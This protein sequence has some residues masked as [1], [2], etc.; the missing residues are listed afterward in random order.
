MCVHP[1]LAATTRRTASGV[2]A[3]CTARSTRRCWTS[4]LARSRRERSTIWTGWC[5]TAESANRPRSPPWWPFLASDEAPYLTR[6]GR[7]D[8]RR[9]GRGMSAA[10]AIVLAPRGSRGSTGPSSTPL[11]PDG[12]HV[13]GHSVAGTARPWS[14]P[15]PA[16]TLHLVAGDL[17]DGRWARSGVWA[18]RSTRPG[19]IDVLVNNAGAWLPSPVDDA[20]RAGTPAGRRQPRTEPDR[21][22]RTLCRLADQATSG[23]IGGG[24]RRQPGQPVRAPRRRRRPP[25][26]RRAPRAGCSRS[27]KG[28]ARE[29]RR[30][31]DPRV[32]RRARLGRDGPIADEADVTGLAAEPA[33]ARDHA[34]R[35]TSPRSVAFLARPAARRTPP[36]PPS[37]SPAPTTCAD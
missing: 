7:G 17:V 9:P 32:R 25:R 21:A 37:T 13:V 16:G 15:W 35:P 31:A 23:T 1:E 27:T 26:V 33:D 19:R 14:R 10:R 11:A 22:G 5:P 8:H 6:I 34:D 4:N 18:R 12:V 24:H 29:L 30:R 28:I 2:N 36:A 20:V 3:V